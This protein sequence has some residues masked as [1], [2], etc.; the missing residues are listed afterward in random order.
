MPSFSATAPGKIILF[1]EHAV[2]YGQPAIAVPV[3]AVQARAIVTAVIKGRSGEI[4]IDAPDISLSTRLD[5]LDEGHPL[6]T[7]I[8]VVRG[9]I[10][11]KE[12]PSCKI[13]VKSNMPPSSGLGSSAAISAAIIRSL[14]AFL[15][16]RLSDDQVSD[17]TYEVEKIHHGTPSGIDNT[18]VAH[19]KPVYY[20]QGTPIE[21]LKIGK[22]FS[23]LVIYSGIPGNTREA[24]EGVRKRWQAEPDRY[25]EIFSRIGS[26]SRSAKGIIESGETGRLGP[27]L[28]ENHQLLKEIGVS[29]PELDQL[30]HTAIEAGALGAKLSGGGLGGHLIALIDGDSPDIRKELTEAGADSTLITSIDDAKSDQ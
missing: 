11:L 21:F 4:W 22:A 5:Q 3:T 17:L 30:A 27:L 24:V 15:G 2:V 19:Q 20:Q 28:D 23:I 26:L 7:T 9:N 13:Q 10:G 6:R 8:E 16:Q 14:S 1:G 18:V 25:N 12:L 29:T